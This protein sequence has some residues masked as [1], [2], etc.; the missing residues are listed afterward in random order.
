VDG[1]QYQRRRLRPLCAAALL[2]PRARYRRLAPEGAVAILVTG[3]AD[4]VNRIG[5]L[6]AVSARV[7]WLE[8]IP[9]S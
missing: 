7:R 6:D 1:R 2:R 4:L 8:E 9:L 3:W 5:E